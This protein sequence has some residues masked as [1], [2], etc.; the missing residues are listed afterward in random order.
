MSSNSPAG[1]PD[2]EHR[3]VEYLQ[4]ELLEPNA[5]VTPE[6]DLLSGSLLDSI[7]VLRLGNWIR[8]EFGVEVR[9][10]DFVIENF[11]SAAAVAKYVRRAAAASPPVV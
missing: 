11:R 9:P 8:D 10:G 6:T 3:V 1:L 5:T 4:R 2:L 7:G